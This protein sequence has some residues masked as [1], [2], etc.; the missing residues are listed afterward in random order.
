M[1]DQTTTILNLPLSILENILS[2]LSPKTVF[3]C[4]S[5]C[6]SWLNLISLPEFSKLHLSKSH[7]NLFIYFSQSS[8][9]ELPSTSVF[10]FINFEDT[11]HYHNLI[12]KPNLDL[13]MK[14]NFPDAGFSL[15]GSIHGFV[16]LFH[17]HCDSGLDDVYIFNP[18]TREYITLDPEVKGLRKY[19]NLVTY[20]FG[21]EPVRMEYKVVRIYQVE[22][23]DPE[24]GS[25]YTS[26][27]QVY[28][29]GTGS[30]RSIGNVK[31]C[32]G[33]RDFGVYLNGKLH[34]LVG[35]VNGNESICFI[36]MQDESSHTF[37]TAPGFNKENCPN[38][39]NLG[40]L[41]NHLSVCDN[42]A[43]SHLDVW[44]MKEYGVTSSWSKEIVISITPEWNWICY[45]MIQVLKVFQDGEILFQWWEDVLFTYHPEKKTLTKIEYFSG[46]FCTF[47]ASIHISNLLSLKN[48]GTEVVH[49]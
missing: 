20:G 14:P 24:K 49:T 11:P 5:V 1:S 22:T 38:L 40:V 6:K 39:L 37:S 29:L 27:V 36:D 30:W 35:D 13:D 47:W 44:V 43:E 34:W 45:Q 25:Y 16:C 23:C 21:L 19:P 31:L 9:G 10:K 46:N 15:V 42:N 12:Y 3:I 18:T 33:C 17:M 48:F 32:F 28:T 26:E 8:W 41:G 7:A 4:R 2:N